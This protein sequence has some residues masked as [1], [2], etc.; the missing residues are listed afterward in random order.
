MRATHSQCSSSSSPHV[1]KDRGIGETSSD[2]CD[3]E[4]LLTR[5]SPPSLVLPVGITCKSWQ[6]GTVTTNAPY[7]A[8]SPAEVNGTVGLYVGLESF[9]VTLV[10]QPEYQYQRDEQLGVEKVEQI[11]YNE[12]VGFGVRQG[13]AER[14]Q[15]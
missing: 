13:R 4:P 5:L 15:H 11:N 14:Q 10:G 3:R 7:S 9:N 8:Y 12:N 6:S 2:S 1:S